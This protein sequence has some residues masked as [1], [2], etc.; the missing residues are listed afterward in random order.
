MFQIFKK[1]KEPSPACNSWVKFFAAIDRRQ[2]GLAD[3]L[4]RRAVNWPRRYVIIGLL[5]FCA[6][7]GMLSTYLVYKGVTG[8]SGVLKV[9]PIKVPANMIAPEIITGQPS[10]LSGAEYSRLVTIKNY[11]DSLRTDSTG[12]KLYQ[13]FTDEYPGMVDSIDH[14]ISMYEMNKNK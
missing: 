3:Q 11:L 12:K 1:N 8:D 5:I 13:S 7:Y 14:I 6:L 2:R 10:M 9:D 4:S